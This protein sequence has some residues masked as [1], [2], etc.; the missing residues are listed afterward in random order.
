MA[1]LKIDL[2][3]STID[4]C[5]LPTDLFRRVGA[6]NE[7]QV[8][9]IHFHL[10]CKEVSLTIYALLLIIDKELQCPYYLVLLESDFSLGEESNLKCSSSLRGNDE[11]VVLFHR[12]EVVI[13][14]T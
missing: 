1:D 14:H 5:N 12:V 10:G 8:L 4:N 7:V 13:I 11:F 9:L 6:I 3:Q 2:I